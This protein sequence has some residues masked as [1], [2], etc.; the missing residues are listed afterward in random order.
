MSISRY[1]TTRP[2]VYQSPTSGISRHLPQPPRVVASPY[3]LPAAFLVTLL[4][5]APSVL[6]VSPL[7][8]GVA[9]WLAL[10]ALVAYGGVVKQA[11]GIEHLLWPSTPL[12]A[13]TTAAALALL[14]E[15]VAEVTVAGV[16]FA[17]TN[18][19][20]TAAVAAVGAVVLGVV[21]YGWSVAKEIEPFRGTS[22]R[23][24]LYRALLTRLHSIHLCQYLV[25]PSYSYHVHI[26]SSILLR[27]IKRHESPASPAV[28][29]DSGEPRPIGESDRRAQEPRLNRHKPPEPAIAGGFSGNG[30]VFYDTT[31]KRRLWNRVR[32]ESSTWM[33]TRTFWTSQLRI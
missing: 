5:R 20:V 18:P 33:T 30:L 22:S 15:G 2:Y 21:L 6:P 12:S 10:V 9:A 4:L 26:Y 27:P 31:H 25:L 28:L 17:T 32:C 8:V 13:V 7:V 24:W 1:S 23:R 19:V 11:L 3:P 16:G 14:Y 29:I